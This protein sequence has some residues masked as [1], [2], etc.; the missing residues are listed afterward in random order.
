MERIVLKT[1]F[2][3]TRWKITRDDKL[4][5]YYPNQRLAEQGVMRIGRAEAR[6]GH[7]VLAIIHKKDGTVAREC[8]YNPP[9]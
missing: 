9:K 1:L 6:K 3:G 2:E 5:S 7:P 8:R 4:Y